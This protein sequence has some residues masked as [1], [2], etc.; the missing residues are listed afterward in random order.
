MRAATPVPLLC[1]AP[2]LLLAACSSVRTSYDFDPDADFASWQSYAWFPVDPAPTGDPRVDNPFLHRRVEAAID[3]VLAARG[4][5]K[6]TDHAPDFFV[7]YHLFTDSRLDV[8]TV[9]RIYATGPRGRS[10]AGAGWGGTGWTETRIQQVDEGT[11]VIDLIDV[12]MRSVAWR[13]TGT[14]RIARDPQPERQTQR[15]NEAVDEILALFPP[16]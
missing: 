4:F 1:T 9:D 5:R 11:L 7:N 13:G 3:R 14:R 8:R 15:V 6:V 16:S 2:L 10:W 12:A